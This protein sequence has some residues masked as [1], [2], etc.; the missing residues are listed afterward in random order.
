MPHLLDVLDETLLNEHVFP[1]DQIDETRPVDQNDESIDPSKFMFGQAFRRDDGMY[2]AYTPVEEERE[3]AERIVSAVQDLDPNQSALTERQIENLLY[4]FGPEENPGERLVGSERRHARGVILRAIQ[5]E[6]A[7]QIVAGGSAMGIMRY[8]L[9]ARRGRAA[10][11]PQALRSGAG[12][13]PG[14][15]APATL[16]LS[17]GAQYG[18]MT[19][20]LMTG[21]E[22][23]IGYAAGQRDLT[24]ANFFYDAAFNGIILYSLQRSNKVASRWTDN[25]F[26]V[27]QFP[28]SASRRVQ[29]G[30]YRWATSG[31]VAAGINTPAALVLDLT[32]GRINVYEIEDLFSP[33]VRDQYLGQV[34]ATFVLRGAVEIAPRQIVLTKQ[35]GHERQQFALNALERTRTRVARAAEL[36][37]EAERWLT[38]PR[39]RGEFATRQDMVN[40]R[41]AQAGRALDEWQRVQREAMEEFE[42][43]LDVIDEL[44]MSRGRV[45]LREQFQRQ[46]ADFEQAVQTMGSRQARQPYQEALEAFQRGQGAAE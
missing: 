36:Q 46:V 33:N 41:K 21:Q 27:D 18:L 28:L 20:L 7:I 25:R 4:I 11:S 34:A 30:M 17:H 3:I 14:S 19:D 44:P 45:P 29:R 43:V 35:L 22:Q 9:L 42:G 26:P 37:T 8:A 39:G 12:V 38:I 31:A 32:W 13:M 16:G 40:H 24:F 15:R 6:V 1:P 5:E 2:V 23:L 10:L